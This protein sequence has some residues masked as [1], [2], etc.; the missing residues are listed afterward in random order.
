LKCINNSL[1]GNFNPK[2]TASQAAQLSGKHPKPKTPL[3]APAPVYRTALA[4]AELSLARCAGIQAR[5]ARLN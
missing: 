5:S 3:H 4:W 1:T 2:P